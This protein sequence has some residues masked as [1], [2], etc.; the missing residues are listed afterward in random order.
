MNFNQPVFRVVTDL[1]VTDKH[2]L[3]SGHIFSIFILIT[4]VFSCHHPITSFKTSVLWH[5]LILGLKIQK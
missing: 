5:S 2:L 3:V 4:E 1:S